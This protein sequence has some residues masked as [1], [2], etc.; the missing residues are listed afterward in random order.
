[1]AP[2][3]NRIAGGTFNWRGRTFEVPANFGGDAI[4]GVCF[5]RAWQVD[6]VSETTCVLSIVF[7]ARWPFGGRCVQRIE[8]LDDGVAQTVEV[9]ATDLA[10]PAG[11]GWHPWFRR[12]IGGAE[13]VHAQIDAALRYELTDMIPTGRLFPVDGEHDLRAYAP[14]GE[15]RLDDCYVRPSG[16]SRLRWDDLELWMESSENVN[17]AMVYTPENA[18]CVEPQTCAIDAFNLE[19][20]GVE[21]GVVVVEAGRPLVATTAWRWAS[22]EPLWQEGHEA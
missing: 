14:V 22:A 20:R 4:H 16:P 9:H 13:H 15:R 8:A 3:P 7:D 21:A 10:F 1:M 11:A 19:A 2:W 6:A 18:V 5:D 12:G 17:H